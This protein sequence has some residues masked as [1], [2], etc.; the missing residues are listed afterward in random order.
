MAGTPI[1]VIPT[2]ISIREYS[3]SDHDYSARQF[4]DLCESAIQNSAITEGPDKIAFIR[5]RLKKGSRVL[6]LMQSSAFASSD[7][8]TDY[9]VFKQNFIT[10]FDGG[11]EPSIV[12]QVAHTVDTLQKNASTKPVWDGLVEANQLSM[13]CLRSLKDNK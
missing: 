3:G 10:V 4:L 8:G 12:R 2:H 6:L 7:I 11:N 9:D 13:D 5:S 1:K